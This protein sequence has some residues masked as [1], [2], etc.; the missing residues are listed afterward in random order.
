MATRF[1]ER[2]AGTPSDVDATSLR[3]AVFPDLSHGPRH[4]RAALIR[5]I[6]RMYGRSTSG[7]VIE[8]SASW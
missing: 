4:G 6:P 3:L 2:A 1:D 7:T 5:S 8:P